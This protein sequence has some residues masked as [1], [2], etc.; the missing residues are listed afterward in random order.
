MNMAEMM[1]PS[2]WIWSSEWTKE[3]GQ[4]P[5]LLCFRKKLKLEERQKRMVLLLS[6]D[7]RYRFYVN[8][9]LVSVGPQRGDLIEWYYDQADIAPYLKKGIN[10][11]AAE[12]LRY[13]CESLNGNYGMIRTETPGF[14]LREEG[15]SLVADDTFRVKKR[16]GFEILPEASGFSP[17]HLYEKVQGEREFQDYRDETFDDDAWA[18]ASVYPYLKVSAQAS[19]GNL[20]PRTVPAMVQTDARFQEICAVRQSRYDIADWNRFLS[21]KHPLQIPAGTTEI[22]ELTAGEEM[23]GYITLQIAGGAG[24]RIEILQSESYYREV[25]VRYTRGVKGDRTDARHGTLAGY[26]DTY[27]AGGFGTTD[28][29]EVYEPFYFR[30]FRFIRLTIHAEETV[31]LL[32]FCYRKTE[33]PLK[34]GTQVMTSDP[35]LVQIWEMCERTLKRCMLDTYVDCPF[36]EQLQYAMDARNEML[37][38]YA[39]ST[40]DRLARSCMNA[41][42][43]S[44]RNDGLT[45]ASYPRTTRGV[46]PSF[47]IYYIGMLYDHMMY[48]GDRAFLKDH[49]GVMDGVLRFFERNLGEDG[50]VGKIGGPQFNIG[51]YWSFIDW[52]PQW[53]EDGGVPAATH[54][55]SLTMESLLYLLG[56]QYA[57]AIAD[58][59]GRDGMGREY[60]ERGE[61]LKA[62][63]WA[64]CIGKDGLL[65][66]GPG[67]EDYSAHCQ[68][69]AIL[70]GVVTPEE[71]AR[72][73]NI[74]L[75]DKERYAPCSVAMSWYLFRAL[76]ITG[77]Y[78]RMDAEWEVWRKMLQNHC[79]TCVEDP[80][81]SRSECH[82]WGAAA[83]YELP[84]AVL[85]VKP[86]APG[87]EK[88]KI[89]PACGYLSFAKGEVVTCRG[90]IRAEW[91]KDEAGNP[92][93]TYSLPG[94]MTLAEEEMPE[95]TGKPDEVTG[96]R[97]R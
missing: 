35:S 4:R 34:T 80:V 89:R 81:T 70:T 26:T 52:T 10:I 28:A 23:T 86:A 12:V 44:V 39:I 76:E 42:K 96:G 21:G 47:S 49:M 13:P 38:T 61:A 27:R 63:I 95:G 6:A 40:D 75:G 25:P 20:K 67:V 90:R 56:L 19:P 37:F 93:L 82:G 14:F 3:D 32:N 55:G 60:R 87:F 43:H 53:Q 41:F 69:F 84:A 57:A 45:E 83:L 73:L 97:M 92:E 94:G 29:P 91:K 79:T 59:V 7:T 30:T 8:G 68:V 74:V 15:G 78:E 62:A 22:I 46:I 71:G 9:R 51:R 18:P 66:D 2:G 17:L 88:V 11:L 5:A 50:L 31:T 33:Y 77:R 85:G 54:K 16:T 1:E 36:Y 64:H 65:Q 72:L 58:F 48:F 24:S